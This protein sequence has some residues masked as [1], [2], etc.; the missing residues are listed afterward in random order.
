MSKN[1]MGNSNMSNFLNLNAIKHYN[2]TNEMNASCS[3]SSYRSRQSRASGMSAIAADDK[4]KGILDRKI[5]K[6]QVAFDQK[7]KDMKP[8]VFD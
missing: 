5:H 4:L 1:M 7:V 6:V 3:Q 8:Y 2:Y